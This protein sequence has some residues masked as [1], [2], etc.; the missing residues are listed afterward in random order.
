M[1][2]VHLGVS[3]IPSAALWLHVVEERPHVLSACCAEGCA[4]ALEMQ[5]RLFETRKLQQNVQQLQQ[6]MLQRK[7]EQLSVDIEDMACT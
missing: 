1:A 5:R 4:I 2:Q 6:A 7:G 3:L